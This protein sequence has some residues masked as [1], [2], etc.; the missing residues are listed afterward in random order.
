MLAACLNLKIIVTSRQ[1]LRLRGEHKFAVPL[2]GLPD[3]ERLSR[4]VDLAT[5]LPRYSAV[6]LFLERLRAIQVDYE[7]DQAALRAIAAICVRL[8]GL[9]LAI[10]LAAPRTRMFTP[11][12]L[13]TQLGGQRES[14]SL[15]LLTGGAR[16]LPARQPTLSRTIQWSYDLLSGEE[17]HVFRIAS[18]F[19]DTFTLPEAE[20]LL[21][22]S[23]GGQLELPLTDMVASLLEKNLL[24]QADSEAEPCFRLL[25]M[26]Q[27]FGQAE[28]ARLGEM[29]R[30][31]AAHAA[32]FLELAEAA[33]PE[34]YSHK[35]IDMI[36]RLRRDV[37]NLRRALRWALDQ[38]EFE[39]APRFG[40]ALW[41]FWLLSGLLSEG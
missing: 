11:E 32:T 17:Q 16:D 19:A 14:S 3:I 25:V 36:A 30:L 41:R 6:R 27:E 40:V 24:R 4:D 10:E 37:D 35:Q 39:M 26:L 13:L 5:I 33:V 34:L 2:L 1:N 18:I 31:Q 20:K 8:D 29:P 38:D 21:V 15:R 12:Q 23:Y 7:P 22:R 28:V 9:P